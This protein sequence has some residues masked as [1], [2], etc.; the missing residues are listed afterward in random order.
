[1]R[2]L[3]CTCEAILDIAESRGEDTGLSGVLSDLRDDMTKA[4][5]DWHEMLAALKNMRE[6]YLRLCN[7]THTYPTDHA[8]VEC[9]GEDKENLAPGFLCAS[10]NALR[11][12]T[13]LEGAKP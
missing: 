2:G 8:C 11:I 5:T 12:I 13:A 10:H 6:R 9:V 3:I 1:M 4:E 7:E